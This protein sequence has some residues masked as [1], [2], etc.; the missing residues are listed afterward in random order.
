MI[1]LRSKDFESTAAMPSRL[2]A[3]GVGWLTGAGLKSSI[4][5]GWLGMT[6]A[7]NTSAPA[8]TTMRAGFDKY[9]L[10]AFQKGWVSANASTPRVYSCTAYN[11]MLAVSH[12]LDTLFTKL[13]PPVY[14]TSPVRAKPVAIWLDCVTGCCVAGFCGH[15]HARDQT[16]SRSW[17]GHTDSTELAWRCYGAV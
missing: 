9:W 1:V 12:T 13:T 3:P 11:A 4:P 17:C 16:L 10:A 2:V 15:V 7:V 8:Y 14:T 5:S 6:A